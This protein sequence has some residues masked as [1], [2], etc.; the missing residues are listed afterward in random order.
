MKNNIVYLNEQ[1]SY[2]DINILKEE[3]SLRHN[4]LR[5]YFE[6]VL[7][8]FEKKNRNKRMYTEN[9]G[10]NIYEQAKELIAQD[11]F[12]GELDHPISDKMERESKVELK[13]VSH[14]FTHVT[15]KN[16]VLYGKGYTTATTEGRNLAGLLLDNVKVGFS[17]RA[18]GFNTKKGS[19]V[20]IVDAPVMLITYDCVCTPSHHD[21]VVQKIDLREAFEIICDNERCMLANKLPVDL[22]IR[23]ENY[24]KSKNSNLSGRDVETLVE[25][26]FNKLKVKF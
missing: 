5:V 10:Q 23:F 20:E 9:C 18:V 3:G 22:A 7:Q 14:K 26:Y 13:T 12:V 8:T 17:L 2:N 24:I 16:K 11:I 15:Y 25:S 21:A 6:T 19:E 1:T 4:T